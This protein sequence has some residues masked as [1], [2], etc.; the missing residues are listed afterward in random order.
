LGA[1]EVIPNGAGKGNLVFAYSGNQQAVLQMNGFSETVNALVGTGVAG[2]EVAHQVR[3]NS[4]TA[5]TL[6]VGDGNASGTFWGLIQNTSGSNTGALSLRKIGSGTQTL[7]GRGTYTGLTRIEGG[8]LEVDYSLVAGSAAGDNL[9]TSQALQLAGGTFKMTGK[10]AGSA[11]SESQTYGNN[12]NSFTFTGSTAGL[13]PGQTVAAAGFAAGTF[14]RFINGQTVIL[15][16]ASSGHTS[17]ADT[18]TFGAKAASTSQTFASLDLSANSTID[19]GAVDGITLSFGSVTQSVNNTVLTIAS[20]NGT[21][22]AGNGVDRLLFTGN[23]SDFTAQFSQNEVQ[24]LGYQGGYTATQYGSVYEIAPTAVPEPAT[25]G[26]LAL[27]T[28]GLL[29]RRRRGTMSIG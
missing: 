29:R 16:A 28:G 18:I 8:V 2:A 15:S 20:W 4:N 12:V 5:V 9:A 25:A 10:T 7:Q 23:T 6:S 1:S 21:V 11:F 14:I 22:G 27:A 17:A 3:N 19:L 26:L 13:R 24:F